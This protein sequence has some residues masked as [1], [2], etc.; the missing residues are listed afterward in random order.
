MNELYKRIHPELPVFLIQDGERMVLYTPG[1][2]FRI[3]SISP[4]KIPPLLNDPGFIEDIDTRNN[5]TGLL[6]RAREVNQIRERKKLEPFL[7]ECLTIHVG[8]ECNLNCSYCYSKKQIRVSKNLSGFPDLK[9]VEKVFNHIA[10]ELSESQ[11]KITVAYHGAGE[12]TFHWQQLR[13]TVERIKSMAASSG[14]Q[15]FNYIATNGCL[16]SEQADWLGFNMDLIG[17]SCDGP[18]D[19]QSAQRPGLGE[20]YLSIKEVCNRILNQGGR[21]EIRATITKKT[22]HRQKEIAS[23]LIQELKAKSIRIEPVYFSGDDRFMEEDAVSFF[24]NFKEAQQYAFQYGVNIEYSGVRINELHSTYC[25]VLRNTLRLTPESATRNCFARMERKKDFV[26]GSCMENGSEF[27]ISSDIQSLK[28]KAL[29]IPEECEE[30]INVFHCSRGCPDF[31]IYEK[32]SHENHPDPFR[33]RL[34]KLITIDHILS[35]IG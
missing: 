13:E 11:G 23:Y 31:C 20:K 30:C 15:V 16:T 10:G 35:L 17:I 19:I 34:H 5:I 12:P 27:R 33:C 25:D 28:L 1:Y 2:Y 8:D 14:I 29:Q 9:A 22:Y 21:F 18:P 24:E 6:R 3:N 32:Q 4:E 26:T 7:A